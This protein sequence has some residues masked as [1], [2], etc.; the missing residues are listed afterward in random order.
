MYRVTFKNGSIIFNSLNDAF[1]FI[2][3]RVDKIFSDNSFVK[4]SYVEDF[5]I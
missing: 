2:L 3:D 1:S 4:I 5:E